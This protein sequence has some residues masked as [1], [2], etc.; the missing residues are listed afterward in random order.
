MLVFVFQW[1]KNVLFSTE[2]EIYFQVEYIGMH[3]KCKTKHN[4]T[5]LVSIASNIMIHAAG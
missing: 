5:G 2:L 3:V 4:I 1:S